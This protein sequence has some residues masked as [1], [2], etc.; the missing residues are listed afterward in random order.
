MLTVYY[1]FRFLYSMTP[2]SRRFPRAGLVLQLPRVSVTAP[3]HSLRSDKE[4]ERP[5]EWSE[6]QIRVTSETPRLFV[7]SSFCF[8]LPA[9]D[10]TQTD[11]VH[12]LNA[13]MCATTRVMCAI[14]EN[15]QTETGIAVPEVLKPFMPPGK[16]LTSA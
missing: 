9:P 16:S 8:C 14:M 10:A 6:R 5:G 1:F 2:R 3:A 13:T 7:L 11:Y 12:M 4:D 15:F